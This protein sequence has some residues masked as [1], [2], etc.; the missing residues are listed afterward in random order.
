MKNSFNSFSDFLFYMSKWYWIFSKIGG[1]L[2]AISLI[3]LL[4]SITLFTQYY[5]DSVFWASF[6]VALL[7]VLV[8]KAYLFKGLG[9]ML[10]NAGI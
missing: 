6:S 8:L 4:L 3:A 9:V 10:K 1:Y 5:A 7:L 2:C